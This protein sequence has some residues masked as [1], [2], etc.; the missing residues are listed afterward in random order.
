MEMYMPLRRWILGVALSFA[1]V[2][3]AKAVYIVDITVIPVI[4]PAIPGYIHTPLF[5]GSG[6]EYQTP[7]GLP[8]YAAPAFSRINIRLAFLEQFN[9]ASNGT[10]FE[11]VPLE[12]DSAP[13]TPI[14][15]FTAWTDM[16]LGGPILSRENPGYNTITVNT[17]LPGSDGWYMEFIFPD[18][19]TGVGSVDINEEIPTEHA[20]VP[21][22]LV[23]YYGP[24]AAWASYYIES[25]TAVPEPGPG[26]M[27]GV[28]MLSL[29]LRRRRQAG[30]R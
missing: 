10:T 5:V 29:V 18:G 8:Q 30:R 27:V 23:T 14:V 2:L 3:P 6:Y 11:F 22:V 21:Q 20:V 26:A 7:E 13:I 24:N 16:D 25:I 19:F 15:N 1:G 28:V 9:L 4:E 17:L 12:P